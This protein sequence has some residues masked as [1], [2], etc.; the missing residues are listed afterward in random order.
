MQFYRRVVK[1]CV[2]LF[3]FRVSS[4]DINQMGSFVPLPAPTTAAPPTTLKPPAPSAVDNLLVPRIADGPSVSLNIS[5]KLVQ[6]MKITFLRRCFL[7]PL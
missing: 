1:V 6:K 3:F 5:Y 4:A 2:L 7:L